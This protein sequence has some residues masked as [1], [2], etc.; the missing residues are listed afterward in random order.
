MKRNRRPAI[1]MAVLA[2]AVATTALGG[3]YL[4]LS[5]ASTPKPAGYPDSSE[6]AS[7]DYGAGGGVAEGGDVAARKIY[8]ANPGS[9]S[10]APAHN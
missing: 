5:L 10:P 4:S 7:L 3:A 1:R 2:A 8:R 6:A 9:N